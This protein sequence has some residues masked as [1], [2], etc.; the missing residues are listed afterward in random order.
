MNNKSVEKVELVYLGNKE[1]EK[2]ES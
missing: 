1:E 2:A